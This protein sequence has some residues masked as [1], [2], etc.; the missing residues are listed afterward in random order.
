LMTYGWAI[1]AAIIAIGVLAYFGVFSPGRFVQDSYFIGAPFGANAGKVNVTGITLDI[2]NGAG[3]TVNLTSVSVTGISGCTS[4]TYGLNIA[5]GG[6]VPLTVLCNPLLVA[7]ATVRGTVSVNYLRQTSIVELS[8][9]GT[10]TARVK[11]A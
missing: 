7:D 6:N 10:I 9:S 1:L 11:A 4:I 8:S 3:E 2:Q 5:A